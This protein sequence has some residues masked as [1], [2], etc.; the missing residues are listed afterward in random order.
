MLFVFPGMIFGLYITFLFSGFLAEIF[1]INSQNS[2]ISQENGLIWLILLLL[3]FV[4]VEYFFASIFTG[5]Y[6]LILLITKKINRG[7]AIRFTFLFLYPKSWLGEKFNSDVKND[8]YT[9]N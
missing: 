6:S 1:N 3:S 9:K 7:E 4:F 5:I 8:Y 2:V